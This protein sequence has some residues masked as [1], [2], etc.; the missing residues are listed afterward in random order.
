MMSW[1]QRQLIEGED[2][3]RYHAVVRNC[4][5]QGKLLRAGWRQ[6]R[7]DQ[8]RARAIHRL[9]AAARL[10]TRPA[11]VQD[12]MT[13]IHQLLAELNP[14]S[15]DWTEFFSFAN[16]GSL[17][18]AALLKPWISERE[19]GILYISF[20]RAWVKLLAR[21]DM[22]RL[23]E[24]YLLVLAP[25]SSPHNLAN[26]V[27]PRAFPGTIF[28]QISNARDREVLPLISPRYHVLPLMASHWVNPEVFQ[29]RPRPQRDYDL[30]MVANFGKV[31]RHHALF[32]ALRLMPNRRRTL[33]I[34]QDQDGRTADT[35]L[36]LARDYGVNDRI[37]LQTN[38]SHAQ[39][40]EGLCRAR[41]S[42][43]L[44]RREG[45]C[46]VV[47]ESLF[48]DTPVALLQGAEIGSSAF[49]NPQTG[50]FLDEVHLAQE[51]DDFIA[52][53]DDYAPRT[54]ALDHI[55]CTRSSRLLNDAIRQ[56][57][58][59]AGQEWTQDV[60]M[61]HWCPDPRLL[62]AEDRRRLQGA[63]EDLQTRFGLSI[64]A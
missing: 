45:S 36:A 23:A 64:P 13:R 39:V 22:D 55:A 10:A 44:S 12:S 3:L 7:D 50:R 33:L 17:G 51:L 46:V 37:V 25:S 38:A 20:E 56:Q 15:I 47:A 5:S 18:T 19:K 40:V 57:Q 32:R 43:I 53:S 29:P 6:P 58:L 24:R 54:W 41:A 4:L 42:V 14:A 28:S 48:A 59:A 9:A 60:A 34:G 31:K 27:F 49:L 52:T 63:C 62:L 35:I 8:G 16:D 1:I 2:W 11:I 26:Y 21:C 61:L 30:V